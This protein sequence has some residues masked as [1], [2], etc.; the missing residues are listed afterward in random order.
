AAPPRPP[1]EPSAPTH[2]VAPKRLLARPRGEP[3][4]SP[5]RGSPRCRPGRANHLHPGTFRLPIFLPDR[6]PPILP[7][8]R[9]NSRPHNR[10]VS[11]ACP[12]EKGGGD[13]LA[14][15]E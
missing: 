15:R 14:V 11:K 2:R 4:E 9:T 7:V 8:G 6:R 10:S 13:C 5:R 12:G 3:E 1:D